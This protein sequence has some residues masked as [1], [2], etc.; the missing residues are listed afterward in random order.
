MVRP[1]VQYSRPLGVLIFSNVAPFEKSLDTPDVG[2]ALLA[3]LCFVDD[4]LLTLLTSLKRKE[5]LE[6]SQNILI[7]VGQS[8]YKSHLEL[9]HIILK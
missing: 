9:L 3:F 7:C 6:N 2:G 5:H 1:K 4:F 8:V